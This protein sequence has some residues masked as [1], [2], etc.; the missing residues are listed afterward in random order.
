MSD[1][2][3]RLWAIVP[4]AGKGRRFG[5]DCPK[6]YLELAN[7]TVI[8]HSL[9]ALLAESRIAGVVVALHSED[10]HFA[11]LAVSR[12]PRVRLVEG[13]A[14]R[15]DSVERALINIHAE[16]G[17]EDWVLVHD[18]ARPCLSAADL[19]SLIDY[20]L[21]NRSGAILAQ[22]VVDTVKRVNLDRSVLETLDRS[23][24]WRAQT[25][26]MFSLAQLLA[27]LRFCRAQAALVT[28]EASAIEAAG[29]EVAVVEGS[30]RNMKITHREDLALA[31]FFLAE[32]AAG[33][34][35]V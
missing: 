13:G 27:A 1:S 15:A 14:E 20:C 2:S 12:D 5:A 32:M 17:D 18:A 8:E 23:A 25:P 9:H 19:A 30:H 26:Q 33:S 10:R 6:Q 4:A 35:R 16:A 11:E 29:G 28:D 34:E 24:L 7:K 21:S 3:P 22:P 31:G